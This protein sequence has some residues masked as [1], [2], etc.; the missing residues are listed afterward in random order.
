M[1]RM[2]VIKIGEISLKGGNRRIF[3]KR[4]TNNIHRQLGDIHVVINGRSG[5][6]Y[7]HYD[8][9]DQAEIDKIEYTLAHVFGIVAFSKTV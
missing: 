9:E 5:R 3:E 1:A 6:F 7:L 2:Y 4:L 8:G